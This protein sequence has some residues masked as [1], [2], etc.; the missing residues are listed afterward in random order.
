MEETSS[1]IKTSNKT[2]DPTPQEEHMVTGA[3]KP[4]QGLSLLQR[5]GPQESRDSKGL[6]CKSSQTKSGRGEIFKWVYI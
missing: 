6:S 1:G 2:E 5:N 4:L 3:L